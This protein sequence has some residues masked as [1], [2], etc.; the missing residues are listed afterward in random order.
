LNVEA[1]LILDAYCRARSPQP[2]RR[3]E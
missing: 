1:I 2:S 3:Q